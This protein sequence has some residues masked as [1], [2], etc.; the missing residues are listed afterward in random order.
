MLSKRDFVI[1]ATCRDTVIDGAPATYFIQNSV[2]MKGYEPNNECV[3]A[4]LSMCA[5]VKQHNVND[6]KLEI[7]QYIEMGGWFPDYLMSWIMSWAMNT[8]MDQSEK[9]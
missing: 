8:N 3:R 1:M 2:N 7:V 5:I 9:L 6:I 4:N